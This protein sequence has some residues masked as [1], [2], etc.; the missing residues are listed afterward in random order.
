M[1]RTMAQARRKRVG[2]PTVASRPVVTHDAAR[3][4]TG[5]KLVASFFDGDG[6]VAV[7]LVASRFGMSKSQL[8]ETVGLR[9]ETLQRVKRLVAPRTQTRVTEMLEIVGRITGWAGGYRQAMAWYRAEPIPALGDRTAESLVKDG[10][11]G[12]VRDYLDHIATGGFA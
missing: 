11:A 3:D 4:M 10:K 12:A 9:P 7:D 5:G 1:E 2:R 8:A 6:V